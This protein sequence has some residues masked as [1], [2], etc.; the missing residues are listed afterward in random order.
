MLLSICV[1]PMLCPTCIVA[2]PDGVD[3]DPDPQEKLDPTVKN[4]RIRSSQNNQD[5]DSKK[6]LY[7]PLTYTQRQYR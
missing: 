1:A 7:N 6:N 2:D 3:P 4:N 5:L